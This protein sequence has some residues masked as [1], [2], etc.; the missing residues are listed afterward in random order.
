VGKG[1]Q[2]MEVTAQEQRDYATNLLNLGNHRVVVSL[3]RNERVIA[4]LQSRGYR[5]FRADLDK[6]VGG[7]GAIH[8]L[9][10]PLRRAA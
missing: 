9:S 10:A 3:S 8:C 4:E 2:L 6:L 5:V 7:Y 1:I